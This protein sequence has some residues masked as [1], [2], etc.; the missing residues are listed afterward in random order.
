MVQF[1]TTGP[2]F[3]FT[4]WGWYLYYDA[5]LWRVC[6]FHLKI[7]GNDRYLFT[8]QIIAQGGRSVLAVIEGYY[9]PRIFNVWNDFFK[10]ANPGIFFVYFRHFLVTI[11]II[12]IEKRWCAWDS[13]LRPYNGR[14]IRN[15]GAMGTFYNW[16]KCYFLGREQESQPSVRRV[17]TTIHFWVFSACHV[18]FPNSL[19]TISVGS[20]VTILLFNLIYIQQWQVAP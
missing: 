4:P 11:S 10:S 18:V 8:H 7:P 14:H 20:S 9:P 19:I 5:F 16:K 3:T 2:K 15:H 12:Q 1:G 13:N 17:L 6:S